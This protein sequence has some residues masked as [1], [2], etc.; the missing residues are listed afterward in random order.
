MH[1]LA[2]MRN[3][4]GLA[5]VLALTP[6]FLYPVTAHAKTCP[7]TL[8]SN[9]NEIGE[10]GLKWG[11]ELRNYAF[12]FSSPDEGGNG[13]GI[14]QHLADVPELMADISYELDDWFFLVEAVGKAEF[15][16]GSQRFGE[17]LFA[18]VPAVHVTYPAPVWGDL[19]QW[20]AE[21]S[22]DPLTLRVGRQELLWGTQLALDNWFDALY[23]RYKL[24]PF[25]FEAFGGL[26]ATSV[27]KEGR[28]CARPVVVKRIRCWDGSCDAGAY[29]FYG[30]AG[31]A[32]TGTFEWATTGLLYYRAQ[33]TNVAWR[34]H[35][36]SAYTKLAPLDWLTIFAEIAYMNRDGYD[37]HFSSATYQYNWTMPSASSLGATLK[38]IVPQSIEGVGTFEGSLSVLFGA[39]AF[40]PARID[41]AEPALANYLAA[42][43]ATRGFGTSYGVIAEGYWQR[44]SEH[45]GTTGTAT[46]SFKPEGWGGPFIEKHLRLE[47]SY[48]L[49]IARDAA[50]IGD[51]ELD[52]VL[53]GVDIRKRL[54]VWLGY[55]AIHLA[56]PRAPEHLAFLEFR[57][58]I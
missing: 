6:A 58:T 10:T 42:R 13:N 54:S 24:D 7:S 39:N 32:A 30:V 14:G 23:A 15:G 56:G 45:E 49:N 33:T 55:A 26:L 8:S 16:H 47:T 25:T 46:L 52:V 22:A 35:L 21:Y 50:G 31:A 18:P 4:F 44:F 9:M 53:R 29:D 34:F 43:N 19:K 57:V 37:E 11:L 51:D 5:L 28:G 27:A 38:V 41:D 17:A 3:V 2:R 40:E 36:V 48:S 12:A 20:Y 1:G